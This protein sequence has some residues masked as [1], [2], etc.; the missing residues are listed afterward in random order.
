MSKPIRE[1]RIEGNIAY[2]PLTQGYEAIIDAAD[3]HLVA[4]NNWYAEVDRRRDGTV[5]KVYAAR[6]V[7][8]G[9]ASCPV[10]LHRTIAQTPTGL[11]TD[12]KNGDGLDNRRVNLRVVTPSQ[13][14]QNQLTSVANTSGFKGVTWNARSAKW[15]AQIGFQGRKF[16]L[17]LFDQ[18]ELAALAYATASSKLHGE[19]GRPA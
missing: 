14:S 18:I 12:H 3:V 7:R 6:K 10:Y 16:Y 11:P 4:R 5:S 15:Q 9:G 1:I 13:N 19:Y 2:I 8:L 17:G